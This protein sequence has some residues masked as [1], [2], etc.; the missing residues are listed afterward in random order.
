MITPGVGRITFAFKLKY[1]SK[2]FVCGTYTE[3]ANV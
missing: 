1:V 3:C 2:E